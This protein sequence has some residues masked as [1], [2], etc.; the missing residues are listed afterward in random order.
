MAKLLEKAFLGAEFARQTFSATPPAGTN[1]EEVLAPEFWVH[2][3]SKLSPRDII[4]VVPEDSAYYAKLFV[5]DSAKLWAKVR[6]LEYVELHSAAS[7]AAQPSSDVFEV[8]FTGPA[9]K[10]RA[11]NKT[12]GQLLTQD[13]FQT[14]EEAELYVS[15]Y[16]RDMAA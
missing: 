11:F 10:W 15:K 4:E 1:I 14:R 8:K 12:T 6:K 7:E 2:V 9:A 13:S 16:S 3:A 5:Y